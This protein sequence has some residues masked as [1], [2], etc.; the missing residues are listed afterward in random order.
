[1]ASKDA[2]FRSVWARPGLLKLWVPE[3]SLVGRENA[4][5]KSVSTVK[6]S[7]SLQ[8][9]KTGPLYELFY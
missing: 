5:C 4:I 8:T 1:M 9:I 3:L 6:A 2:D 7:V